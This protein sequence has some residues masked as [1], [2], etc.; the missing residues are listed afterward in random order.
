MPYFS[1][2]H[3]FCEVIIGYVS[4]AMWVNMSCILPPIDL[5]LTVF[6]KCWVSCHNL[7]LLGKKKPTMHLTLQEDRKIS[8]CSHLFQFLA[9]GSKYGNH[10][11][12][13]PPPLKKGWNFKLIFVKILS[14]IWHS[15]MVKFTIT[16]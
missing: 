3:I 9:N 1:V 14:T 10:L 7:L 13:P 6:K 8:L 16:T 11:K 5:A 2:S 15:N 4:I 12:F